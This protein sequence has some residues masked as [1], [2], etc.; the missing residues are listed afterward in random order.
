MLE[1]TSMKT[2]ALFVCRAAPEGHS[3]A[4]APL[5]TVTVPTA[6][7]RLL[8]D[9]EFTGRAKETFTHLI[10]AKVETETWRFLEE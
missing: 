9:P 3:I 4:Q 5:D 6:V 2:G 10:R 7:S 1:M 8:D